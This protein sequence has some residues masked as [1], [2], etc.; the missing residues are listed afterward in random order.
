MTN[1]VQ[2]VGLIARKEGMTRVFDENGQHIPV[3]VLQV[4]NCQVTAH[5]TA[6]KDGYVAVQLGAGAKKASRV[7]RSRDLRRLR[8]A[9]SRWISAT[10]L[11]RRSIGL[12]ALVAGNVLPGAGTVCGSFG[13][14]ALSP[15]FWP[16]TTSS[17]MLTR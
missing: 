11:T 16:G 9:I 2:R 1:K 7:S 3:T 4:E 12:S 8:R 15:C 10:S 6:E 14:G 13:P 5:K 17:S